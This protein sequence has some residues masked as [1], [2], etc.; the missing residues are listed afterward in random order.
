MS[1][2]NCLQRVLIGL[3][4]LLPGC[5][6]SP[7]P[8]A[9]G[10]R[11][12][13]GLPYHG[14]LTDAVELPA[15]GPGF[16]RYRPYAKRN[17]GTTALVHA[18]ERAA[19]EVARLAPS[20]ARL[21]VGDLSAEFGGRV[22]GH[23]SHRTGRDVDLLLYATTLDGVSV[24]SPGFVHFGADG[25]ACTGSG[26]YV[27]LDV[28]REWILIRSLLT[29]PEAEVLWIFAS[30]EIEAHVTAY[31]LSIGEPPQLVARAISVLHQPRDSANHDDHLHVRVACTADEHSTGCESG[32]PAWPWLH[33]APTQDDALAYVDLGDEDPL[34][35][36]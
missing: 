6:G 23:A 24:T 32:G 26:E 28:R 8:L 21:L 16:A 7:T 3:S 14:T 30:R 17:Y 19:Q 35:S 9:P 29:D 1:G 34:G 18:V 22:S 5:F 25:L 10:L 13:V 20:G 31:A 2:L 11:G 27:Q 4:I 12:S 36:I 33:T 15:I